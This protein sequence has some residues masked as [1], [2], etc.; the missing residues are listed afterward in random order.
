MHVPLRVLP[1]TD[2]LI[3]PIGA[4][5]LVLKSVLRSVLSLR[6]ARSVYLLPLDSP[7]RA[8]C[9]DGPLRCPCVCPRWILPGR[10][11]HFPTTRPGLPA[12]PARA[13]RALFGI[14]T[15]DRSFEHLT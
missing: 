8:R 14:G 5:T 6:L 4:W 2:I 13:G 12:L 3:I 7:L 10:P 9:G 11:P 15:L 1:F